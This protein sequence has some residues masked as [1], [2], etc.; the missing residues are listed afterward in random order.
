VALG[1]EHAAERATTLADLFQ[2]A[3][4]EQKR[5]FTFLRKHDCQA[6]P[7][8]RRGHDG[9]SDGKGNDARVA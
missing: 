7:T 1:A 5:F 8:V 9:G 4:S 3:R 2:V 6:P